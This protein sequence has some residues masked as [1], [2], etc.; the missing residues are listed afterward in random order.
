LTELRLADNQLTEIDISNLPALSLLV[1]AHNFITN[2]KGM[3]YVTNLHMISLFENPGFNG[4][5]YG[6]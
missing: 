3:E 4:R 6:E 2:V 5:Q 1:L